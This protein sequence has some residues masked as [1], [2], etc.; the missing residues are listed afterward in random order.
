MEI[1]TDSK[2]IIDTLHPAQGIGDATQAGFKSV[3]L[4]VSM[5]T[6][7]MY[8]HILKPKEAKPQAA[9]SQTVES[10]AKMNDECNGRDIGAFIAKCHDQGISVDIAEAPHYDSID[11]PK[12]G[13]APINELTKELSRNSVEMCLKQNI[14]TV[15]V[16]PLSDGYEHKDIWDEN[17]RLYL[18]LAK[19]AEKSNIK[20]LITNEC[21]NVNGHLCRGLF[22]D[23]V[24]AK[25]KIDELNTAA[26]CDRFG[27][28]LDIGHAN[29]CGLD[30]CS[31][32][33][34][35]AGYV[36]AVKIKDCDGVS[37]DSMMIFTAI[38]SHTLRTDWL[39]VIRGLRNIN[40]DGQ[41]I[42][43]ASDTISSFSPILKP[44]VLRLL[45]NTADYISWQIKM[46]QNL[47]KY[48]KRVLFGAGNMCR[49]YMKCYG[50]KYPVL[51]TCDNNSTLWGTDFCGL[52]IENP[53]KLKSLPDGCAIFICNIYYREIE[54]QLRDMG[55]T[56]QIEFFND[57]YMPSF[58]TDRLDAKLRT[59]A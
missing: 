59:K 35:L 31:Y 2:G 12:I 54:K 51:F 47:A 3:V 58:Y 7:K 27:M 37:D 18:E 28:C 45:K 33:S 23:A 6:W 4:D 46:E 55:I 48:D 40:F 56:N 5:Y 42:I 8:E 17:R 41:M 24:D 25:K 16:R 10:H 44:D 20:I 49:N 36:S 38:S 15:I 22:S 50:S 13:Y 26:R 1:V 30:M 11:V 57:E 19:I 21:R 9:R 32:I 53:E 43:D 34:E 29:I 52:H 14:G 39:G